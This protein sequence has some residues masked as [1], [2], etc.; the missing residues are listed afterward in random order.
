MLNINGKFDPSYRY[1]MHKLST[2]IRKNNKTYFINLDIIA[3]ELNR[4][5]IE[6]IKWYG[7]LFGVGTYH[8]GEFALNGKYEQKIIQDHIQE[9]IN[10]NVLCGVCG[11]PETVYVRT[12][13]KLTKK[14]ISCGGV[15]IVKINP[16]M[17]KY[18]I[19]NKVGDLVGE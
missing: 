16:K 7:Y 6:I 12:K 14:C 3:K 15:S 1:K 17:E 2:M 18:Y 4:D 8:L 9:F 5:P 19:T 11:N 10:A 13:G